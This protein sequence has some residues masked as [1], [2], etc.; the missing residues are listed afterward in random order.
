[1]EKKKQVCITG[2]TY[3]DLT[4]GAPCTIWVTNG[5]ANSPCNLL[6]TLIMSWLQG[7]H[8]PFQTLTYFP[9]LTLLR[10]QRRLVL[11]L[12]HR[13]ENGDLRGL[14]ILPRS[15]SK[16]MHCSIHDSQI[17]T[18]LEPTQGKVV[19]DVFHPDLELPPDLICVTFLYISSNASHHQ[20]VDRILTSSG[21]CS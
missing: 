8:R 16:P 13:W 17:Q 14:C 6:C 2:L 5:I 1:M 21:L 3:K 10:G 7:S 11:P 18:L 15:P 9:L 19:Q 12:L 4:R 20:R